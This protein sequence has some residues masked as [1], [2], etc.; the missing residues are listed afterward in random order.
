MNDTLTVFQN[1][2]M[3]VLTSSRLL[4]LEKAMEMSFP[5]NHNSN[6]QKKE[7]KGNRPKVPKHGRESQVVPTREDL[8]LT[9]VQNY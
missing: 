4:P 7:K 9:K 8:P 1:T 2:S 5:P 3:Q 6:I